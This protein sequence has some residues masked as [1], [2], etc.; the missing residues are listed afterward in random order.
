M[1]LVI[2]ELDVVWKNIGSFFQV[3]LSSCVSVLL[4]R[5]ALSFDFIAAAPIVMTAV[6]EYAVDGP[7]D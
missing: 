6:F 4:Y 3:V 5:D 2:H 1:G 7:V